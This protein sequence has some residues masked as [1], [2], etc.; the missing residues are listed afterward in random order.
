[1]N[2]LRETYGLGDSI[3]ACPHGLANKQ[4][5]SSAM[6]IT[7]ISKEAMKSIAF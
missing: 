7:K 2:L 6:D 3:F 4:N 5:I 1:M